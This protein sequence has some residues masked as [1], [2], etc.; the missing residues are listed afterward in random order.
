MYVLL[1]TSCKKTFCFLFFVV[2]IYDAFVYFYF[3]L[4]I[5]NDND[6]SSEESSKY[7]DLN[8]QSISAKISYHD[9]PRIINQDMEIEL[10]HKQTH[11]KATKLEKLQ[12]VYIHALP[13]FPEIWDF[14]PKIA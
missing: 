6:I 14:K 7:E 5:H 11:K 1:S 3:Y 4:H 2:F 10:T 8:K 9:I 13:R 12:L